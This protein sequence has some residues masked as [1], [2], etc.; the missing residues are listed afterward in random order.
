[1]RRAL[2]IERSDSIEL[3]ERPDIE[4]AA[5]EVVIAPVACGLCGTDLELLRGLVDPAF[6]RYPLTIGH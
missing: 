6:V 3:V 2:I 4:P 5:G 1:M